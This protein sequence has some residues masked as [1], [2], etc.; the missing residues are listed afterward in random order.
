MNKELEINTK[1]PPTIEQL[2]KNGYK[3][4]VRH[5]RY[6]I[7]LWLNKKKNG[8]RYMPLPV[9]P[10]EIPSHKISPCGGSTYIRVTAP[11]GN[12]YVGTS[13]CRVNEGFNRKLGVKIA[14]SRIMK[15]IK[16][17]TLLKASG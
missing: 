6:N 14:L 12:E 2:R 9:N 5:S 13:T 3:V 17:E 1:N 10:S 4:M 8:F 15:E 11:D 7:D 16:E